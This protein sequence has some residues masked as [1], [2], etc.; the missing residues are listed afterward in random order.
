[1]AGL[2]E[3]SG[4]TYRLVDVSMRREEREERSAEE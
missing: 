1:L 3:I 4:E 2:L